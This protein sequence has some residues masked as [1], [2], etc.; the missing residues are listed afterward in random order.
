MCGIV[1]ILLDPHAAEAPVWRGALDRMLSAVR[2]RGPD[3]EGRVFDAGSRQALW[4]GHRRL[5]VFAPGPQGAQ[6]MQGPGPHRRYTVSFNGA[7][8]NYL[9][10]GRSLDM[11]GEALR[12]DTAVLLE[13][14]AAWGPSCLSRLN[15]MFAFALWDSDEQ[16]LYLCR[17]RFGE[18][19]LHY[20]Q[21]TAL[22][23]G[24]AGVRLL[25]A[26]EAKALFASRLIAPR[27]HAD[28]L[29]EFLAAHDIDHRGNVDGSTI[30]EG[31]Q[32]VPAGCYLRIGPRDVVVATTSGP[33][34][35]RY[36]VVTPPARTRPLD[37]DL[38]EEARELLSSSVQLRLRSDVPLGG[39]LSGGL[40]SSLLT[41][42]V[43]RNRGGWS[44]GEKPYRVFTCQFPE[45]HDPP[46]ESAWAEQVLSSLPIDPSQTEAVR[47]RPQLQDFAADVERVLFHQEAPFADAS[48]CAHFALMR[49]VREHGVTVLLSGQG[50]DEIFA[51]YPSYYFALLGTMLHRRKLPSLLQHAQARSRRL[52][53]S[54]F[55]QLLGAAYHALPGPLRHHLYKQRRLGAY[56]LSSAGRALLKTAPVRFGGPLPALCGPPEAA[57]SPFDVYLLDCMA[58]WALPHILRHD[59]RNSMAFG[60]ESRAPY[61]DHRL[62]ELLLSVDPAARIGD[63][64]TKRLLREVATGLL[65]EPVR[66]RV[67][68]LGFFSPQRDWLLRS[69]SAVRQTCANLPAE[70]AA[71]TDTKQLNRMLDGFYREQR[72][73]LSPVVWTAFLTSLFLSRVVPRLGDAGI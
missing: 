36:F 9:E 65:P 35:V 73:E 54:V 29:V 56:P 32:Q 3:G 63:G 47:V 58:R 39:S 10:I 2:H 72:R 1:G 55:R 44:G 19:P 59:D 50:G 68:K 61:L 45:S 13:A 16:T 23:G 17:D 11:R 4:L 38:I 42:L 71:L 21:A 14:W 24:P 12:S 15:G 22:R 18:K 30:F 64:F 67:D 69:E 41:A 28:Q 5:D 49:A 33:P 60:I 25:F 53:E 27:L 34:V 70:L 43:V 37:D 20:A 52:G 26:S 51:G 57:W 46:D 6:P 7:I 31:V 62:L 8:Y 66:L 40:D 48:V